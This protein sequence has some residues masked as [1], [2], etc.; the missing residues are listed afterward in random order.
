MTLSCLSPTKRILTV[1]VECLTKNKGNPFTESNQIVSI[2]IKDGD[3]PTQCFFQDTFT[4]AIY[5]LEKGDIWITFNGKFDINWLRRDLG[6]SPPPSVW[7]VQL[8]EFLFSSQLNAY[9]SLNDTARSYG[10][11]LKF[12]KVKQLWDQGIDTDQ[13]DRAILMEYGNYDVDLTYEVFKRQVARFEEENAKQYKLFRL[14]CNDL[15]V[16]ADIEWNGIV[17][18][19]EASIEHANKLQDQIK[20]IEEKVNGYTNGV[21]INLNSNEHKSTLLYGGKIS[22]TIKLPIGV[23]KTGA[24]AGEPKFRNHEQVYTLPRLVEPLKGSECLKEGVFSVDEPTLLSLKPNKTAKWIIKQ[25]LD[26][27][28]LAKLC[29]TYLEGLP[30]LIEKMEWPTNKIH[31]TLNQ[32]SAVTGR[33]SSSKP[34]I[35]NFSKEPKRFCPSRFK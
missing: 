35:Q 28:G 17:Y 19:C 13:I 9:P 20:Q 14:H 6:I 18:D 32:C 31:S 15:L 2:H 16:L 34:N 29:S 30:K 3:K 33:L 5:L 21:P 4:R 8:A 11:P 7:D 23:F 10:F 27:A 25:I 12:E 24:R 22:R 26:R 1:D